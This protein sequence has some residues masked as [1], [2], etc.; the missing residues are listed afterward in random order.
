MGREVP[1]EVTTRGRMRLRGL[2]AIL[3]ASVLAGCG[4]GGGDDEEVD[5]R[6]LATG[7]SI[8]PADFVGKSFPLLYFLAQD[9]DPQAELAGGE[10]EIRVVDEDSV[11][12]S[13][14]GEPDRTFTRIPGTDDFEGPDGDGGTLVVQLTNLGSYYFARCACGAFD[15]F[16]FASVFG[17][18]TP[19]D[20]RPRG[21]ATYSGVASGVAFAA[22]GEPDYLVIPGAGSGELVADFSDGSIHGILI[23]AAVA[24]ALDDDGLEDDAFGTTLTL[25]GRI[26]PKGFTGTVDGV[27]AIS[28]DG[29][30]F[31]AVPTTFSNTEVDGKFF[32]NSGETAAAAYGGDVEFDIDDPALD[33]TFR[34]F[35]VGTDDDLAAGD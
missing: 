14:P 27:V 18:E 20:L 25:D 3:L 33:G 19:T 11:V 29:G 12:I 4:G 17:F 8:V 16:D 6:I 24:T 7:D 1:M 10:G 13:L 34:G 21:T 15:G 23:D 26:D 5:T 35:F 9:G 22:A 2:S 30:P 32:G 28:L 31:V